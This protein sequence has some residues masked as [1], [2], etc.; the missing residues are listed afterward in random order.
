AL[1]GQ[2]IEE[3][4]AKLKRGEIPDS[5][6]FFLGRENFPAHYGAKS[7]TLDRAQVLREPKKPAA[8][9]AAAGAMVGQ[10]LKAAENLAKQG[11]ECAVVN[12][13]I[14]NRPDLKTLK[15]LVEA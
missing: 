15:P 1:V 11:I 4:A 5:Y 2:A 10:A 7:Y 14:I 8:V 6:V 3:Y 12:P 13:S 9:I